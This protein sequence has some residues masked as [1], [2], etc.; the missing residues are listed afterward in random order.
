MVLDGLKVV[1]EKKEKIHAKIKMLLTINFILDL[2]S[3]ARDF[4]VVENSF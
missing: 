2:L 3:L 1:R 4:W